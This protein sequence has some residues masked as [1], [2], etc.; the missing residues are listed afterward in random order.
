[1]KKHIVLFVSLMF[2]FGLAVAETS[3]TGGDA[4]GGADMGGDMDMMGE[5]IFEVLSNNPDFSTLVAAIEAAGLTETLQGDGPFTLFAP[6]NEAFEQIPQA[7]LDALLADPE[8]LTELLTYHVVSGE[9]T[10]AD[11]TGMG[12]TMDMDDTMGMD[13]TGGMGDTGGDATGGADMGDDTGGAMTGDMGMAMTSLPT[14]QGDDLSISV[15]NGD[16]MVGNATVT[17]ADI[18]ASNGVIHGID[19]VL[20]P[21]GMSDDT[22]GSN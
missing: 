15:S 20:M 18:M 9:Y 11:L 4:T 16:V 13:D 5:T 21:M 17:E 2:V 7:D 10:A 12:D 19:M 8:A 6:T 22:G 14:V 1:M 3:D